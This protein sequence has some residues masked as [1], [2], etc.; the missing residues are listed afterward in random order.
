[1]NL[2]STRSLAPYLKNARIESVCSPG[3]SA[4]P[5]LKSIGDRLSKVE[6]NRGPCELNLM[7]IPL[8][9]TGIRQLSV[10]LD[11]APYLEISHIWEHIGGAL[12]TLELLVSEPG[13]EI[14]RNIQKYC[15]KLKKVTLHGPCD[16]ED[17]TIIQYHAQEIE[18]IVKSPKL[19]LK[20]IVLGFD[21]ADGNLKDAISAIAAGN[22]TT[23]E[24]V[25]FC[26]GFPLK[27]MFE[28]LV[29]IK[30]CGKL[31]LS[32]TEITILMSLL[33]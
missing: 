21:I 7:T 4:L 31:P 32:S 13:G 5:W 26:S 12:E 2:S 28:S 9:C 15:R 10:R 33:F 3:A 25:T 11:K 22:V 24:T 16:L 8:Y 30:P 27:N 18:A 6:F 19:Y 23:L 14:F 29:K 17:I 20:T 1:M